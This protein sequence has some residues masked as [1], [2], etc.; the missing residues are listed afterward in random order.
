MVGCQTSRPGGNE[1]CEE[2]AA[3]SGRWEYQTTPVSPSP[4]LADGS[5]VMVTAFEHANER[6]VQSLPLCRHR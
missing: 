5:R 2:L 3:D 4:V 1:E 6:R